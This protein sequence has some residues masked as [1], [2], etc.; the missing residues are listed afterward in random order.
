MAAAKATPPIGVAGMVIMGYPIQD[1]LVAV[2]LLYTILQIILLIP[3]FHAWYRAWKG[4]KN[5]YCKRE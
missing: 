3:K 4:A 2:T 1:W 5:D